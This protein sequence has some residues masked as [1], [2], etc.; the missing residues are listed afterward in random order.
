M[1][2]RSWNERVLVATE[3]T[4]GT[5][6]NPAASQAIEVINLDMGPLEQGDTRAKKD[7]TQGRDMTNAF[8]EGRVQPI[9]FSLETSIKTRADADD[10]PVESA[11]YQAAGFTETVN[12]ATN[13]TYTVNF[14]PTPN[15][16]SILSTRGESTACEEAEHGRGGV[17]KEVEWTFGEAELIAK[18]T[19][20]FIGKYHLGKTDSV[21]LVDGSD[22]SLALGTN[23]DAYRLGLGWYQI[24]SEVVRLTANDYTTPTITVSR[25][26][27]STSAVAHTT[28]AMYPHMPS[29]TLNGTPISEANVT[30]TID[31]VA[32]RCLKGAIKVVTG[33]DHLPGET[34]SA[35]VQGA[36]VTRVDVESTFDLI[37][38]QA[39]VDLIGKATER[40]SVAITVVCGTGTGGIVT[41]SLPYSEIK[42]FAVPA[43]GNDVSVVTVGF[44]HR[45]NGTGNNIVAMT[46]T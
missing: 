31:S 23:S 39:D 18:F 44:R 38:S 3:S 30:V 42:P 19:G 10:I 20:Q 27:L 37:L 16:L 45:G 29:A 24:E 32:T 17:I 46:L 22:T 6:P 13:V 7:K 36:K 4:F 1:A 34:G 8:V 14:A 26:A 21:T 43:P 33:V 25:G 41:F 28:V 9:P 11:L 40:K 5:I 35:Y 12:A 15:T 2:V